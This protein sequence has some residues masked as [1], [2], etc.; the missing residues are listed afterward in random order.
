VV[1]SCT[2]AAQER[3]GPYERARFPAVHLL[4]LA[5]FDWPPLSGKIEELTANHAASTRCAHQLGHDATRLAN[6]KLAS[7]SR[8]DSHRQ[9]DHRETG[10]SRSASTIHL[11]H[12]RAASAHVVVVHARE[13]VVHQGVRVH[14]LDGRRE[15]RRVADATGGVIGREQED[16]SKAFAPAEQTIADCR[17]DRWGPHVERRQFALTDSGQRRIDAAPVPINAGDGIERRC[18]PGV[19]HENP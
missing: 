1:G 16:P 12:R 3:G 15:W 19:S 7:C 13:I 2:E 18:S 17:C 9:G 11:V 10:N 4:E 14:D 6:T 5:Q 8:R